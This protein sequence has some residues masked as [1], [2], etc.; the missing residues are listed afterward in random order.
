TSGV[1]PIT[2]RHFWEFIRRLT[3]E[4]VT[5]FVTTHYMDEARHCDRV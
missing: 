3:G 4:G 1:D 2:R 5:V